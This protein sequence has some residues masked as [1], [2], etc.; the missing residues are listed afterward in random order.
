MKKVLLLSLLLVVSYAA[1]CAGAIE[2]KASDYEIVKQVVN[3]PIESAEVVLEYGNIKV[4][5]FGDKYGIYNT[6][7]G[8]YVMQP[9][10]DSVE[11]LTDKN[12]EFKIRA[13]K[14]VGYANSDEDYAFLTPYEDMN[15]YGNYL[16]IKKNGK[17]G[18]LDKKGNT[19]LIPS[20]RHVSVIKSGD[21]E[22]LVGNYDGKNKI[23][24]NTG[25]LVPESELYTITYDE[26]HAFAND[27][28]PVFKTQRYKNNLVYEK[29]EYDDNMTYEIKEMKLPSKTKKVQNEIKDIKPSELKVQENVITIDKKVYIITKN[30]KLVGLDTVK[31]K[32]IVPS[33]Y[34]SIDIKKPCEHFSKPVIVAK[35]GHSYTI[36]ELNGKVAAEQLPNKINIY[37][38]GRVYNYEFEDGIWNLKLDKKVVGKLAIVGNEQYEFTKTAFHV[39]SLHKMNEL[40][41]TIL[42]AQ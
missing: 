27:I 33:V 13:K 23:F 5:K 15:L 16:R 34:D 17:Y 18:L 32:E 26:F 1:N 21:T 9:V 30:N 31:G 41:L 3:E 40:L 39:R 29:K 7:T 37:K 8:R 25:K 4:L 10:L 12:N 11:P 22:Y 24:Y 19:L 36:Y 28:R 38:Y 14:L 20:F 42:N 35:K 6:K 2:T